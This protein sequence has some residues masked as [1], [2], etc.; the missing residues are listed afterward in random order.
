MRHA[1]LEQLITT[2]QL[3]RPL[4]DELVFVGGSV[5]GLLITDEAAG[6]P[7]TTYDVDAIAEIVSYAE[8][9]EFGERL[10]ALGFSEDTS[11]GAPVCRWVQE[12]CILD[13]MPLDERILGFSNTWYPAALKSAVRQELTADLVIRTTSAPLFLATK[14]QAFEGG[15]RGDVRTSKDLEDIISVVDGRPTLVAEVEAEGEE[16]R[17]YIRTAV[18]RLLASDAFSDALPGYLLPDAASQA[19]IGLIL[20]RLQALSRC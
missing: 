8:Y 12:D 19:R 14:L 3:L 7:R 15:H 17:A 1:N 4:L 13:V 6:E 2:A 9:A 10:R 18:G 5:T 16:L 11:E 20:N